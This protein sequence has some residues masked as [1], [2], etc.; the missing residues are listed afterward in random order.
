Q[1]A[2]ESQDPREEERRPERGGRLAGGVAEEGPE[3]DAQDQNERKAEERERGEE[4]G[5]ARVEF[6]VLRE[7]AEGD[8]AEAPIAPFT[9]ATVRVIPGTTRSRSCEMTSVAAP[10]P[11][12]SSSRAFSVAAPSSSRPAYGSSRMSTR[13]SG[14]SARMS[15]TRWSIPREKR[16]TGILAESVSPNRSSSRWARG[17]ASETP[18]SLP[19]NSR[20]SSGVKPR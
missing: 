16:S 18:A 6:Q 2:R 12:A 7:D 11:R 13:G 4:A 9:S 5:V 14:R 20:F 19:K 3:R 15:A 17:R 10:R 1:G 8:H